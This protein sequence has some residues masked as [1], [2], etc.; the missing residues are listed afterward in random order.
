M[1]VNTPRGMHS[2]TVHNYEKGEALSSDPCGPMPHTGIGGERHFMAFIDVK[3]RFA[4]AIPI[5][6]ID[7]IPELF[8][9]KFNHFIREYG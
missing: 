5:V 2:Q 7:E 1:S 3:T 9:T 8:D 6:S 4:A